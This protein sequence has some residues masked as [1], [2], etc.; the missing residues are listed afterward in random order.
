MVEIE[1]WPDTRAGAEGILKENL[2]GS[3]SQRGR[4][5][6]LPEKMSEK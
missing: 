4:D 1:T 2:K 3:R 6:G 5:P